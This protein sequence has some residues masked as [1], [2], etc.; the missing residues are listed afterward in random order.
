MQYLFYENMFPIENKTVIV[1]IKVWVSCIR[2]N[3]KMKTDI[4]SKMVMPLV[5]YAMWVVHISNQVKFHSLISVC[6]VLLIV[7]VIYKIYGL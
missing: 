6:I 7:N 4:E 5:L 3:R 1:D 2:K